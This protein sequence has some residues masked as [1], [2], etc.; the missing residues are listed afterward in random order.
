MICH[1]GVINLAG[2][3]SASKQLQSGGRSSEDMWSG[4]HF[5][6]PLCYYVCTSMPLSV[7]DVFGFEHVAR[8]GRCKLILQAT[9]PSSVTSAAVL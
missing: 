9:E 2:I 6:N 5:S 3:H 8:S 1:S 4:I 7:S